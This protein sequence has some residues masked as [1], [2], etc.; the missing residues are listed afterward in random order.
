MAM[1]VVIQVFFSAGYIL[2]TAFAYFIKNWRLLEVALTIPSVGFLL[3]W[4]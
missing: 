2:V 4:W 3:Y 1:G